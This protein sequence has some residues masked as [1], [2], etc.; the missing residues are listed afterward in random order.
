MANTYCKFKNVMHNIVINFKV[1]RIIN[2][3]FIHYF[4]IHK[5]KYSDIIYK[6]SIYSK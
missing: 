3:Y 2:L 6:H 4:S 5:I 1:K